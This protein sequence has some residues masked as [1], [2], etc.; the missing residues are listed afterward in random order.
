MQSQPI[1][2]RT[3]KYATIA[4]QQQPGTAT[5]Q[6]Q[7]NLKRRYCLNIDSL[8]PPDA[9][10]QHLL[11]NLSDEI[12][13]RF[14]LVEGEL[15]EQKQRNIEQREWNEEII[16]RMN[17]IEDMTASTDSKVDTIISKLDSW[18]IPTKR[19]GVT[20]NNTEERSAPYPHLH[21]HN[22]DMST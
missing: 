5:Q 22:G 15:K 12:N 20:S 8:S 21:D 7:Q 6:N 11:D 19:R 2:N 18:D 9:T 13:H 16:L 1:A 3:V 10:T 17:Y 4:Q 14:L